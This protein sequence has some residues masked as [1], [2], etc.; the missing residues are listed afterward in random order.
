MTRREIF[1]AAAGLPKED[2]IWLV[3]QLVWRI[4]PEFAGR[5]VAFFDPSFYWDDWDDEEVDRAYKEQF[6][7]LNTRNPEE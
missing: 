2:Q 1:E 3:R 4:W 6:S 5:P 7:K